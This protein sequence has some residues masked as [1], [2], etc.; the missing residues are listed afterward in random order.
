MKAH[1]KRDYVAVSICLYVG[2]LFITETEK[3]FISLFTLYT[4]DFACKT[5]SPGEFIVALPVL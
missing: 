1:D 3:I 5:T 2:V 4:R